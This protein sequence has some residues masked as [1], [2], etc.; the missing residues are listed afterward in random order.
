MRPLA[1]RR[2]DGVVRRFGDGAEALLAGLKG[3]GRL[4]PLGHLAL[5]IR[6][7]PPQRPR[8]GS[9]PPELVEQV[10]EQD[11]R[12][13]VEE[14]LKRLGPRVDAVGMAEHHVL[15]GLGARG[16]RR[17]DDQA[18]EVVDLR[19]HVDDQRP[20]RGQSLAVARERGRSLEPLE[21]VARLSPG[22]R[23][24]R[25]HEPQHGLRQTGDLG[26]GCPATG[27]EPLAETLPSVGEVRGG[28][29]EE[30][31][32]GFEVLHQGQLLLDHLPEAV[33]ERSELGA[34]PPDAAASRRTPSSAARSLRPV[35]VRES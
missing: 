20:V 1:V 22:F 19:Q 6:V 30:R 32:V 15:D 5:E 27:L 29:P 8:A 16:D 23:P 31:V 11:Q 28:V 4:L 14:E 2:D 9:Q 21:R 24:G 3:G 13:Q 12:R 18:Q 33:D 17:R 25:L 26:G 34:A 10:A 7:G 35:R